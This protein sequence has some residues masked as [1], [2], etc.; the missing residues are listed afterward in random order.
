M[1]FEYR[2]LILPLGLPLLPLG[3]PA[4]TI[5]LGRARRGEKVGWGMSDFPVSSVCLHSFFHS[6][7]W[8][9]HLLESMVDS[10]VNPLH[11]ILNLMAGMNME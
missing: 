7:S 6:Q 1:A 2:E 3:I 5:A 8:V 10:K 11:T 9:S 4:S